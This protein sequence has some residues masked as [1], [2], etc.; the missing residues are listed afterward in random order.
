M[1]RSQALRGRLL[2]PLLMALAGMRITPNHLTLLSLLMGLAF[3]PLFLWGPK[4]A[5]LALLL[6]HIILDGLDGPLA[7]FTGKASN[8]GSFTDT[9]A[10]Q[11]VVTF[12]TVTLIHA[13]DVGVWPGSLYI[14]FYCL[15]VIFAMVRS[16]LAIPYSWLVRPR[17]FVYAWIP[18]ELYVWRGSLDPVLWLF[19]GLLG[20]KMVTGFVRIRRRI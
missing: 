10:D 17:L 14:F 7:R 12:S 3:C 15:V 8:R 11:V 13:G 2:K 16:A 20:I 4:A 19:T 5:A 9:T 6:A 1:R 18:L